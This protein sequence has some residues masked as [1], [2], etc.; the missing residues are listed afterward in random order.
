[1]NETAKLCTAYVVGPEDSLYRHKFIKLK[2]DIPQEYPLKPPKVK[3]I[4]HTGDRIHP[5]LYVEGKVC[6]SILGTW[7]G[8]PWSYAMTVESVLRTIQSLLDD[9]PY[10]HEPKQ[11]DRPDF[12]HYVQYNTWRWLLLDYLER[13]SD[14]DAKAFLQDHIRQHGAKMIAELER[15]KATKGATAYVHSPYAVKTQQMVDYARLLSDMRKTVSQYGTPLGQ[16][17]SRPEFLESLQR[18]RTAEESRECELR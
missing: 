14:A 3:F 17:P 18:K 10:L 7:Q 8:E 16:I 11:R 5:N 2:F 1:M 6:L 9:K 4:Q 15:Q 13:E 12:N